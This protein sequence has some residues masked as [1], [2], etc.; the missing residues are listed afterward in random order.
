MACIRPTATPRSRPPAEPSRSTHAA[1]VH[2]QPVSSRSPTGA[3]LVHC[4]QR[5]PRANTPPRGRSGAAAAVCRR[6]GAA[7]YPAKPAVRKEGRRA[8]RHRRSSP[9]PLS[10]SPLASAPLPSPP[11][12][13]PPLPPPPLPPLPLLSLPPLPLRAEECGGD[14]SPLLT[15]GSTRA[16]C[17]TPRQ[18]STS[19]APATTLAGSWILVL[20][21]Y[22]ESV[23]IKPRPW[24]AAGSY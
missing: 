14:A 13:S 22:H 20:V 19:S 15:A 2:S 18:Y 24:P 12:P 8:A 6:T 10:P 11:L 23:L 1:P 3:P 9:P 16:T 21:N 17:L 5:R 4:E 7:L